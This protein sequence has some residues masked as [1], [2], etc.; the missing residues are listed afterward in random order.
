MAVSRGVARRACERV[1]TRVCELGEAVPEGT[2]AAWFLADAARCVDLAR[3]LLAP[4]REQPAASLRWLGRASDLLRGVA[5]LEGRVPD[6]A[7]SWDGVDRL[8][9]IVD[10]IVVTL[11]VDAT[12]GADPVEP[13]D[14]EA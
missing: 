12:E 13:G 1:F 9:V 2:P 8:S 14:G 5:E 10:G 11:D 6:Y 4:H 3:E 7:A